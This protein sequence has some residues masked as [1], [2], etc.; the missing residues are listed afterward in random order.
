MVT[1]RADATTVKGRIF[2]SKK[3]V[4]Q[5]LIF[6]WPQ[7]NKSGVYIKRKANNELQAF[8]FM[9]PVFVNLWLNLLMIV[10]YIHFNGFICVSKINQIAIFHKGGTA[11]IFPYN[12]HAVANED[13]R[14]A[15]YPA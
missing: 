6:D 4:I 2:C 3:P 7:C 15:L 12:F 1:V 14:F 10:L 8:L 9:N 13:Y 11:A 5:R